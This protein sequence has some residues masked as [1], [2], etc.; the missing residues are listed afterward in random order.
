MKNVN[1]DFAS[2]YP[3][4]MKSYNIKPRQ[5]ELLAAILKHKVK[6]GYILNELNGK[7]NI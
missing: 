6:V 4:V 1:Y 7:E 3:S 5:Y 2:L